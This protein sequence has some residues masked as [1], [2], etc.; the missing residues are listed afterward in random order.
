MV[1][2]MPEQV[3]DFY[4]TPG[5]LSTCMF[6]TGL[7]PRTMKE[8][9]VP[10]TPH[11]KAM[12]RALIQ[13]RNPKNYRLVEEA[14]KKAGRED[15]IGFDKECLIRQYV[16][17]VHKKDDKKPAYKGKGNNKSNPKSNGNGKSSRKGKTIR[18]VHKKK[19]K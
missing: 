10:K 17:R 3:Q 18:Q 8:V 5:T 12:Q 16:P 4:P 13:Y 2:Y 9:Y 19:N 15:L 7:D 14:L 6:Y 1:G 11:E